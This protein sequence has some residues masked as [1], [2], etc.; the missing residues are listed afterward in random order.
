MRDVEN[1]CPIFPGRCEKP[2]CVGNGSVGFVN[3]DGPFQILVL[4]VNQDKTRVPNFGGRKVR[5]RQVEE[6]F[7]FGHDGEF[8]SM[9]LDDDTSLF[10]WRQSRKPARS[11]QVRFL[12]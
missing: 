7:R 10:S 4:H 11:A 12:V 8:R 1:W 2:R 5:A 9:P 3:S 6:S